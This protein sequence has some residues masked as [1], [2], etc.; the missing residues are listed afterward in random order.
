MRFPVECVQF[1]NK[2][3]YEVLIIQNVGM[4]DNIKV[5][6]IMRDREGE[7]FFFTVP[8]IIACDYKISVVENKLTRKIPFLYQEAG[9]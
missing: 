3:R 1:C 5:K 8:V 4:R 2:N 6:R 7:Y 9:H